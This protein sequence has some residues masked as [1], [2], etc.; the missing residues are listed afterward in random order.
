MFLDGNKYHNILQHNG[1]API[2][3]KERNILPVLL[4]FSD[5]CFDEI[6]VPYAYLCVEL[7]LFGR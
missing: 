5:I 6:K 7:W 4:S 1:M 2:K 3:K